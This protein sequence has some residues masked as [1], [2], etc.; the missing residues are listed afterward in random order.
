MLHI[1]LVEDSPSDVW[2]MREA[3]SQFKLPHELTVI[4]DGQ[5]AIEFLE[6]REPY[7]EAS[8]PDLVLLDIN[9]PRKSGHEVLQHLKGHPR[10]TG[11]VT[12]MLSCSDASADVRQAYDAHANCYICKPLDLE[13][14]FGM[15]AAIEAFW[16]YTVRLPKHV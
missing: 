2:L 7:E 10:L 8:R 1:L 13:G 12:I 3:L 14:F 4:G 6:Q 15:A 9:L 5:S 11:V 16:L